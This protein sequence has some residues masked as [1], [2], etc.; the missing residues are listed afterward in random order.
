MNAA[1]TDVTSRN[2]EEQRV[3]QHE[4]L[5]RHVSY[6]D[7]PVFVSGCTEFDACGKL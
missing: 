1:A 5:L 4:M 6:A 2:E 7:A 3:V